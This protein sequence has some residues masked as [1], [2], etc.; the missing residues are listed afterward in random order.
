[1]AWNKNFVLGYFFGSG[2]EWLETQCES[3]FRKNL[4]R[5]SVA[6]IQRTGYGGGA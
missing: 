3:I 1:M 2:E 6:H 5:A 4:A